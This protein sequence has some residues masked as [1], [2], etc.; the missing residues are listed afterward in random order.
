[1]YSLSSASVAEVAER[2]AVYNM[3]VQ[4][5]RAATG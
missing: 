2:S 1:M 4:W 3:Y 5:K